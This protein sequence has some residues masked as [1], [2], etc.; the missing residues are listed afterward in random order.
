MYFLMVNMFYVRI[1]VHRLKVATFGSGNCLKN[2]TPE[3]A[4]LSQLVTSS[5]DH[6]QVVPFWLIL[7]FG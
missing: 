2:Y 4:L 5:T 6:R 7:G 3:F 1:Y